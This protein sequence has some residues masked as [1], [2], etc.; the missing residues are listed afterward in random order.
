SK[1]SIVMVEG[2]ALEVSEAD[3]LDALAIGHGGIKELIKFQE[4]LLAKLPKI[5]K[6]AWSKAE[7]SEQLEARVKE[8]ASNRI[9]AALNQPDKHARIEA[10][11]AVKKEV[12]DALIAEFPDNGRDISD[13]VG[14]EEYRALRAQ[15]LDTKHRVDGRGV[16]DVRP[17]T[18]EVSLL[19]RAH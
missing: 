14:D 17:I 19:P 8:L 15:V 1:D 7:R 2:G 9:V 4:E 6:M 18:P 16:K 5:E 11:E 3:C 13:L 12:I 10:V